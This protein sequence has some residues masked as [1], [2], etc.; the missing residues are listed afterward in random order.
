MKNFISDSAF[1]LALVLPFFL[2]IRWRTWGLLASVLVGWA[3]VH[4]SNVSFTW[5][6]YIMRIHIADWAAFGWLFMLIWCLPIY[7]IVILWRWV[8]RVKRRTQAK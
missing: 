7:L 8:Q 3:L 1:V 2:I 5:E 4:Y 6:S